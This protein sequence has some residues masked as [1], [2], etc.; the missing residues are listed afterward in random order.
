MVFEFFMRCACIHIRFAASVQPDRRQE[1]QIRHAHTTDCNSDYECPFFLSSIVG[2]KF[3]VERQTRRRRRWQVGTILA[4]YVV[5]I[6]RSTPKAMTNQRVLLLFYYAHN[7]VYGVRRK[8]ISSTLVQIYTKLV[9]LRT[10][11][12][13]FLQ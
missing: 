1:V 5:A 8:G 13:I 11:M 6:A 12:E 2:A 10:M 9:G 7:L 4:E 3:C